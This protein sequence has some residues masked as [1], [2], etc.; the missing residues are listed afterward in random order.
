[1]LTGLTA[2]FLAK[3][4]ADERVA[5]EVAAQVSVAAGSG[6]DF[7]ASGDIESAAQAAGLDDA[8]TPAV[9]D[10]YEQAQ[11]N[12]LKVGLLR[13]RLPRPPLAPPS[14]EACRGRCRW[15]RSRQATT[16]SRTSRTSAAAA[17]G[18]AVGTEIDT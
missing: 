7:V 6:V 3:I 17:S 9:V 14:R 11:L 10:D 13:R 8:T 4:Q 5:P 16:M 12:A 1:M 18:E 15:A 2:G